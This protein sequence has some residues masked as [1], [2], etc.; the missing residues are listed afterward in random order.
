MSADKESDTKLSEWLDRIE[1]E[2]WQLELILSGFV[3]FL[4]LHGLEPF[5]ALGDQV[6]DLADNNNYFSILELPYHAFRLAYY[7]LIVSVLI[8]VF[9]R[10]LW[11]STIGLRSVSGGIE[12]DQFNMTPRFENYLKKQIPSFDKYI[13][14]LDNYCSVFFA[15]TFLLVFSI[16]SA[17]TFILSLIIVQIVSR[18][19]FG[20]PAF[21]G[22]NNFSG[23]DLI[24]LIYV[25]SGLIYFIDFLTMGW[26][27]RYKWFSKFYYPIY[28]LFS[29]VTLASFYRPIYYNLVDNKLGRR[30]AMMILPIGILIIATMSLE[31]YGNA[32][33]SN[34]PLRST[35]HWYLDD[36]YEDIAQE[37]ITRERPSIH[38]QT[39]TENHIRLFVPYLS[40]SH[41][42]TIKHLCP[43]L[44]PGYFTGIKLRGG[45]EAGEIFNSEA[46][47]EELLNCTKQLWRVTIND[48]TYTDVN[49]RFYNHPQRDQQGLLAVI[50]IHHLDQ[51]EHFIKID[52]QRYVN[53]ELKWF[54]GRYL[55]FYKG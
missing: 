22:D 40:G 39:I 24:M 47:T 53:K 46:N 38:A 21:S 36:S 20:L 6:D 48:S 17:L 9:L 23:D 54:D 1:I 3:I 49:F 35:Q 2:S 33:M 31:Y 10:G 25:I 50:P 13:V 51:S 8:H 18:K 27:K 16:I 41:E 19:I 43:T 11:I 14:R 37:N 45:F 44:E 29:W 4:L 30:L 26:L 52:R 34:N 42:N 15:Y 5:H 12:W 7:I 32:Y 55:W 28:R